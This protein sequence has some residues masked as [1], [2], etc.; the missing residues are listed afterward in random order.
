M[1]KLLF[2]GF[3]WYV[4]SSLCTAHSVSYIPEGTVGE[5]LREGIEYA[6]HRVDICLHDF[7]ALEIGE[8]LDGAR[9]R[10]VQVRVTI[11]EQDSKGAKGSLA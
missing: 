10:G 11:L 6:R 1:K 9:E 5:R 7:A 3:F 2:A 8:Y 4:Y